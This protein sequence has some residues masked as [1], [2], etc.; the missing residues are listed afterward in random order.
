MNY[1]ARNLD[2]LLIGRFW[3]PAQLGLYAR[4]YQL[5]LLPIDQMITPI[6]AVAVPAL[7]RLKDSPERYRQAYLRLLE[8]V[9]LLTMP[10]MV[11][12]IVS[13]DWLVA[14][15]LGPKWAGVSPIFSLLGIAGLVQP[16]AST[17]GWLFVTQ[18]RTQDML[19]VGNDRSDYNCGSHR[20]R[21]EMGSD[22]CCSFLLTHESNYRDSLLFWFV[23]RSG[24]VRMGDF[25]RT[26]GPVALASV[27]SFGVLLFLKFSVS[28]KSSWTGLAVSF[29]V[30][31]ATTLAILVL[32]P[33]GRLALDLKQTITLLVR[34]PTPSV[35][36]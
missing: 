33:Q 28:F 8:K 2:N 22:R 1:F 24:P 4:A 27:C 26:I 23:S 10:I 16:L 9:A 3:G 11:F 21:F 36:R 29:I 12:M 31:V 13:S 15:V 17:T 34:K 20:R 5:L 25:Y 19:Q 14:I 18:G 32:L 6:T 35:A 7:S 30:V